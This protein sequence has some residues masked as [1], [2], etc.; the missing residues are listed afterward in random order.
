[1]FSFPKY[2]MPYWNPMKQTALKQFFQLSSPWATIILTSVFVVVVL[3]CVQFIVWKKKN[4]NHF[5]I[6]FSFPLL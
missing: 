5:L 1:M 2:G 4:Q 6:S 3:Y